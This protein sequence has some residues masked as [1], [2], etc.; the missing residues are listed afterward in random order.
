MSHVAVLVNSVN[1]RHVTLC[2]VNVASASRQQA[3]VTDFLP[4]TSEPGYHSRYSDWLRAGRLRGWSSSPGRVSFLHVVQTG[5][6][7][8]PTTYPIGTGGYFPGG[9][10]TGA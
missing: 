9:K 2:R 6:G 10:A 7:V 8:H 3:R 5:S 1:I 4:C